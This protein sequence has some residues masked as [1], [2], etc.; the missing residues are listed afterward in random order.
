MQKEIKINPKTNVS[1]LM[2]KV[3]NNTLTREDRLVLE[4]LRRAAFEYDAK[5]RNVTPDDPDYNGADLRS[6]WMNSK[7]RAEY[8]AQVTTPV[9]MS[10]TLKTVLIGMAI[11]AVITITG[12]FYLTVSTL[13]NGKYPTKSNPRHNYRLR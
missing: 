11:L 12:L 5:H 9:Y 4:Q 3:A 6:P 2:S 10:R 8:E 7:I 1:E 13:K